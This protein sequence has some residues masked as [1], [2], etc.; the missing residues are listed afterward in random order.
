MGVLGCG[1]P[2]TLPSDHLRNDDP[3]V[4]TSCGLRTGTV[5]A[6]RWDFSLLA[7][8]TVARLIVRVAHSGDRDVFLF[9]F[10]E[11]FYPSRTTPT[12]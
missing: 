2:G 10:F 7:A 9:Y 3:L 11:S 1:D 8:A 12:G 5:S 4:S 6:R